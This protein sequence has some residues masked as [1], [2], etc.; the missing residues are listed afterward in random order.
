MKKKQFRL[1]LL[2]SIIILLFGFCPFSV[3]AS[4]AKERKAIIRTLGKYNDAV[5]KY[6]LNKIRATL[7]NKNLM[8][9]YG[10]PVLQKHI[11]KLNKK[12]YSMEIISIKI[13]GNTAVATTKVSFYSA[14]DDCKS[15][16]KSTYYDYDGSWSGRK[17][18]NKFSKYLKDIYP[19]NLALYEDDPEG[20]KDQFI[21]TNK[22]KIPLI[23][24]NG[25]WKI[26]KVTKRMQYQMDA[27]TSDFIED[28]LK[29]PAIMFD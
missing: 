29:N 19:E 15:A 27:V 21:F 2:L 24:V 8:Y 11:R 26:Q 3:H 17:S 25:K 4:P 9:W 18:L 6:D 12:Y 23:K 28:F 1:T 7:D 5:K 13:K 10:F 20:F 22:T 16:M 14:Y